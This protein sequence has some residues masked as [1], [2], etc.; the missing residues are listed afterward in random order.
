M[1]MKIRVIT[2][3]KN[4]EE[5]KNKAE[6]IATNLCCG[7]CG[8]PFDY[9]RFGF[10]RG[11]YTTRSGNGKREIEQALT[12][13]RAAFIANIAKIRERL[14]KLS[15][16]ELFEERSGENGLPTR[17]YMHHA[18]E[19][20][21]SDTWLYDN[22]GAGIQTPDHLQDALNKWQCLYEDKKEPNPYA[23]LRVW[24]SVVDVHC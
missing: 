6:K 19:Y 11:P 14:G 21:G 10:T 1:H 2:Y 20:E 23:S 18:G 22:D 5:A 12:H 8:Q 24:V 16:D 13:Q 4:R 9:W 7:D 17:F 3:A 15:D